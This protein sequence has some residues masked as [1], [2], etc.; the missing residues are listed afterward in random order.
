[1]CSL[2][3][4]IASVSVRKCSREVAIAV[5]VGSAAKAVPFEGFGLCATLL[6]VAW[7]ALC[8]IHSN[9]VYH[10][11]RIG[12]CDR[13]ST[14]ASFSEDDVYF[15]WQVQGSGNP[16]HHFCCRRTTAL[17]AWCC[18][19][20]FFANRGVRAASRCDDEQNPWQSSRL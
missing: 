11:P 2:D 12:L 8:C 4:V 14:F 6:C 17:D 5:L 16:H 18:V 20:S 9:M 3:V 1:M 13:R 15:W 10:M 19:F 7:A